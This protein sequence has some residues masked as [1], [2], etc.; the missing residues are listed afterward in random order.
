MPP[1]A[2]G[3]APQ[4]TVAGPKLLSVGPLDGGG[5]VRF[6]QVCHFRN[7]FGFGK[8]AYLPAAAATAPYIH[9]GKPQGMDSQGR[10][11]VI[12]AEVPMAEVLTYASTLK[13]ITS[14]RGS[15]HMEFDHYAD[16]P[17]QIQQ[18]IIAEA[19]KAKEQEA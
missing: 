9:R 3:A 10:H 11:Q 4:K 2:R 14:D 17:S 12:R 15:Y 6:W 1:R 5:F 13:S 19:N 16:V 8:V 7:N 18:Q